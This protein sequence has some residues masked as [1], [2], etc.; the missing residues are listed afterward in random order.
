MKIVSFYGTERCDFVYYLGRI[1]SGISANVIMIDNS[2]TH[3]LFR[4]VLNPLDEEDE[5]RDM[6]VRS[7]ITY[8]RDVAYSPEFFPTFD[9]I[10]VH[11]GNSCDEDYLDNSDYIIA[12]PDCKPDTL[13]NLPA[14]P[15]DTEYILRDRAGKVNEKS[16]AELLGVEADRIAG[17]LEYDPDD[18]AH[19]I[20]LLYNG[21]QKINGL[22]SDMIQGLAYI[23][24]KVSGKNEKEVIKALKKERRSKLW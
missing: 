6:V 11:E 2:V 21:R 7:N 13:K 24:A 1:L 12:M 14:L 15:E 23:T 4:T 5:N 10:V 19:Y 9:Y 8:L 16:A 20:S 18:Y 3:E 17:F 22:S